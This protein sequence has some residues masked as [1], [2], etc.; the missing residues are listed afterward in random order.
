MSTIIPTNKLL[1]AKELAAVLDFGGKRPEQAVYAMV[2][3]GRIPRDCIV[4]ISARRIRFHPARIQKLIDGG[5]FV[6]QVSDGDST[7]IGD[8]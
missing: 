6:K 5:G 1:S 8:E 4:K 2:A 7:V 3:D